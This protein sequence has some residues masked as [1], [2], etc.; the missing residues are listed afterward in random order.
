MVQFRHSVLP[1][2]SLVLY[3]ILTFPNM[4]TG[5]AQMGTQRSTPLAR[6]R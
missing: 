4:G 1:F 2:S 6:F 5:Y 3:L